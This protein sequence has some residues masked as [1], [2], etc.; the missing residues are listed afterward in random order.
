VVG[1]LRSSSLAPFGYLLAAFRDGLKET[2]FVESQNVA[3]EFRSA[4]GQNDRLPALAA[5]LIQQP[6]AVIF[7]DNSSA[8][9]AKAATVTIP[10]VFAGGGDP[11]RQGLVA[12]LNQPGG[13][14]TG[15]AFLTGVLG[16]KRLELLRQLVPKATTIALLVHPGTPTTD[17]ERRDVQDAAQTS[18]QQIIILNATTDSDIETVF[19]KIVEQRAGA[20]LVGA[21]PFLNSHRDR[22]IALA[23]R[24]SLPAIYIQREFVLAG[25]LMSYGTSVTDAYRQAGVYVGRIL[26][27]EKPADLPVV[28]S[29]K[30]EL[31]LNLKTAKALSLDIPDRVLALADEVIE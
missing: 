22:I 28:Q 16:A 14:V 9:A 6:A 31:V 25:G 2:G 11:V 27:G 4:E 29:S 13:N 30:F 24:H 21:G 20:L 10:I 26:K 3:I 8:I 5:D 19:P 17:T 12:S 15:V 1:F 7:G 23:A 18:G